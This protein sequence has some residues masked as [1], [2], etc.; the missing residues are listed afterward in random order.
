MLPPVQSPAEDVAQLSTDVCYRLE[1][2]ELDWGAQDIGE[3]MA[4]VEATGLTYGAPGAVI[5][6]MGGAGR[7]LV[8]RAVMASRANGD[9]NLVLAAG[10]SMPG[11]RVMLVGDELAGTADA[12]GS[13]LVAAGWTA[14]PDAT[15]TRGPLERRLFIRFG[16]H[17]EPYIANLMVVHDSSARLRLF[18]AV[19]KVP[20]NVR[21]P[22]GVGPAARQR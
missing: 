12:V 7:T 15:A 10:G 5:E 6:S 17:D 18:T 11:C 19:A 4:Q 20:P 13:A 8:S 3:Q 2:G 16:P 22:D 9:F 21:L 14:L 1:A